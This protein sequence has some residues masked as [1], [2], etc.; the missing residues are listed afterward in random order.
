MQV[1]PSRS[2]L[3]VDTAQ[4]FRAIGYYSDGTTRDLS[5][6][7][8]W[9]AVAA[10]GRPA[11]VD[12]G[13]YV[14]GSAVG[15]LRVRASLEGQDSEAAAV[16]TAATLKAVSLSPAN[17]TVAN[18]T[19]QQFS[20]IATF[21]DGT[22]QDVT[23]SA[24]W[25]ISDL[26]GHGVGTI[27]SKG[28]AVAKAVGTAQ[29]TGRYKTKSALTVLTVT[30]ATLR[31]LAVSPSAPSIPKGSAVQFSLTG[32]YS[33]GTT[34]DLTAAA[35]WSVADVKGTGVAVI[36]SGGRATAKAAGDAAVNATAG[37][38]SAGTT[39]HVTPALLIALD[40]EPGTVALSAGA[41]QTFQAIGVYSDGTTMNLS[42]SVSWSV[43]DVVGSGVASVDDMGKVTALS[44]GKAIL[45]ALYLTTSAT[46]TVEVTGAAWKV[47]PVPATGSLRSI[48]GAS[49]HDVWAVG[50]AG[51]ILHF[52]GTTWTRATS[53]TTMDLYAVRG[54][55]SA[56]VW[57]SGAH[58]TIVHWNGSVWT[59]MT[60]PSPTA[61]YYALWAVEPDMVWFVGDQS[62]TLWDGSKF[63]AFP[64]GITGTL[65]TGW[66]SSSLDLWAAGSNG[67]LVYGFP[68]TVTTAFDGNTIWGMGATGDS[69]IWAVAVGGSIYHYDMHTWSKVPSPATDSLA[70][71]WAH[72]PKDA[73]AV[74][75]SSNILHWD[76]SAW[77]ATACPVSQNLLGVWGSDSGVF[78]TGTNGTVL[79]Y[80]Y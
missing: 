11:A 68:P 8:R 48:W 71:V 30:A 80:K 36:T 15:T 27:D 24:T 16:V 46:A 3:A 10:D 22:T 17:P 59:T 78:A 79:Y 60:T 37:G 77:T 18:G 62:P 66:A 21:S 55:G 45:S 72:T 23:H 19:S 5:Q 63:T 1:S 49:D 41:T 13:G 57:A 58:G 76:G 67:R 35:T 40:I 34:Q 47:M 54:T 14:L 75:S 31:S 65:F 33:D 74:G 7:V 64:I 61:T 73:W 53:G 69:D 43:A 44:S 42:S 9:Q 12:E 38:L 4:K 52:D 32:T 50:Q 6:E 25:A 20:A 51:T 39:L 28:L 56:D 2:T 70:A 29:V 26:S